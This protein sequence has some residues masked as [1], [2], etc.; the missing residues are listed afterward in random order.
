MDM[1]D[2]MEK[3][4]VVDADSH[5][6]EPPNLWLDRLPRKWRE[7]GPRMESDPNSGITRWR[8]GDTWLFGPGS[9]S[10][11]GW[12]DFP[13]SR[14][15]TWEDIDVACH[16]APERAKWL[17]EN[18]IT[19]QV[20]YPNL[21]AFEG[22]AIMALDDEDFKISILQAYNDYVADFAS[23]APGRFIPIASLPFWDIDASIAEMARCADL[24]HRGVLWAATSAKH[25][26][27]HFSDPSWDPFYAA[28]QEMGMSIN[29]HV[30]VGWTEEEFSQVRGADRPF[31]VRAATGRTAQSFMSN[32]KTITDLIM[33]GVCERFPQLNF[34]SVESGFGWIPFLLEALDWQW[35]NYDGPRIVG[36][37][38]LPSEYFKRQ[39]FGMFW[40][41]EASLRTFDLYADNVMFETDFPHT[42]SLSP[43]PGSASPGASSIV[44]RAREILDP[45]TFEKVMYGNA[46]RVYGL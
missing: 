15:P 22:Y 12:R 42:T 6:T 20:L 21:C 1:T 18:Q 3:A 9:V 26:L 28:A 38:L 10:H 44:D 33:D 2:L 24:G 13:P 36:G 16:D 32:A 14:P 25:G 35:R 4:L 17:D 5:L 34:V 29:F 7:A 31:D 8:L 45:I 37:G 30:G 39:I 43:G 11:A 19:S 27:P 41:E 46:A 40:F 23:Q